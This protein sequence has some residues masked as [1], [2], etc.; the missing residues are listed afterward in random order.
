MVM[1]SNHSSFVFRQ[2]CADYPG[3]LGW[4]QSPL[5]W[6]TPEVLIPFA[7][8]NDAYTL[9][10]KGIPF[11]P[12]AWVDFLDKVA[13]TGLEPLWVAI[14]DVVTNRK[15]TLENWKPYSRIAEPYGWPLAFVVQDGMTPKDVPPNASVVFV[16]GSTEWKWRNLALWTTNFPRVHVG[17][18]RTTGLHV[19]ERLGAESCDGSGWFSESVSGKPAR[20]LK[21]WLDNPK[22][23]SEFAL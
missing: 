10:R 14:P 15:A 12:Q 16:G 4:L 22:P 1:P 6:K 21:A 19:C 20:I 11:N 8:D 5:C 13:M 23:Q 2:W 18:V 3:R 17:R 7:L 9:W